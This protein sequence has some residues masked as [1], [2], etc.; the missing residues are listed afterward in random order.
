MQEQLRRLHYKVIIKKAVSKDP[1]SHQRVENVL[2]K[3]NNKYKLKKMKRIA[4]TLTLMLLLT[5]GLTMTAQTSSKSVTTTTETTIQLKKGNVR[6]L[7]YG[8]MKLHVYYTKD[9]MNDVAILLEKKG[10]AVL[11]ESPAFWDNFKEFQ[12]YIASN[13]VVLE[14]ILP[15][16]HPLGATLMATDALKKAAVYFTPN[17][18]DYWKNGFG[19]VMKAGIPKAF[20][21][22]VDSNFYKPTVMLKEGAIEIAGIKLIIN[23]TYD[24]FDIEIPE[25]NTVYVHILGHDVH[26]EILSVAH[27]DS[28]IV[29]FKKYLNKG[30]QTYLSAHY[31]V[32][33]QK[34]MA[35]KVAYLLKMKKIM[36]TSKTAEAFTKN[37]KAAYPNYKE[38]Y[39][40]AT[41]NALYSN[42]PQEHKH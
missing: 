34:D 6:V 24:G 4:R 41:A 38:G 2:F 31:G 8:T 14:G 15:A 19:A 25:I 1:F 40:S 35:V 23:T 16:Y 13:K 3:T 20:G 42:K 30:Y 21:A 12:H 26:S 18:L 9:K 22:I 10:K 5:T 28:S 7:D 36:A 17:M 27:L 33:S 32:E 39:L 29:N 11:I 37:M